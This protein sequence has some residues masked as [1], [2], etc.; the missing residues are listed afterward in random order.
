MKHSVVTAL[1]FVIVIGMATLPALAQDRSLDPP[2][3]GTAPY[4]SSDWEWCPLWYEYYGISDYPPSPNEHCEID[5]YGKNV[6][7]NHIDA[8][9]NC[10]I[11]DIAIDINIEDNMIVMVE[12]EIWT[13]PCW[14]F[15]YFETWAEI[16]NLPGGIYTVEVWSCWMSGNED[17][18]C[19]EEIQVPGDRISSALN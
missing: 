11:D 19:S 6:I 10:C 18:R 17:L 12:S 13:D 8:V 1:L 5:V 9:Y 15:C 14:C 16:R 4:I 2:S 7:I 3:T